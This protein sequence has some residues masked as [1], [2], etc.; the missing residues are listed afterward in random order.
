M[1]RKQ[2]L[3]YTIKYIDQRLNELH[4]SKKNPVDVFDD[5][6]KSQ[7]VSS[8]Y[9]KVNRCFTELLD[10]LIYELTEEKILCQ[11]ELEHIK[12]AEGCITD[13]LDKYESF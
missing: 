2:Q 7:L 12:W 8:L 4:L 1:N 6:T 5:L 10:K 11:I 9:N 3:Q 13:V